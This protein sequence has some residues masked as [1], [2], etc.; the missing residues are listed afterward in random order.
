MGILVC[1][2]IFLSPYLHS[3]S[4]QEELLT[5]QLDYR[6]PIFISYLTHKYLPHGARK[7]IET[8]QEVGQKLSNDPAS[9]EDKTITR[10]I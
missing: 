5:F 4:L 10:S 9:L 6:D 8:I 2:K 3:Y 7:L 1:P